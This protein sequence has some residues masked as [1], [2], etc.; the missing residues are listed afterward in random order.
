MMISCDRED[1]IASI[2]VSRTV[3]EEY[4]IETCCGLS[5]YIPHPERDDLNEYYKTPGW[6]A[7]SG[8]NFLF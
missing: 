8:F 2:P 3:I 6:Y 4:D 7:A 5:C 1:D